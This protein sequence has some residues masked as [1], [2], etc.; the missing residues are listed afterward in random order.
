MVGSFHVHQREHCLQLCLQQQ[1]RQAFVSL[2][3]FFFFLTLFSTQLRSKA[4]A[5][6]TLSF[7]SP[8]TPIPPCRLMHVV[9][10]P[11]LWPA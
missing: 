2:F 3:S 6:N 4:R 1:P 10:Q 8:P 9:P 11:L 7:R 5:Q